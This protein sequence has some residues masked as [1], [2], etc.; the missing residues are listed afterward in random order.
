M[1]YCTCAWV[2]DALQDIGGYIHCMAALITPLILRQ[3]LNNGKLASG[4]KLYF[5]QSGTSTPKPVYS[6]LAGTVAITQPVILDASGWPEVNAIYGDGFY[7]MLV[8]DSTGAQIVPPVDG[9]CGVGGFGAGSVTGQAA[10]AICK[11]YAEVRLLPSTIDIAIVAGR[12][13][14]GD[15]GEGVFVRHPGSSLTDDDGIVLTNAGGSIV[16]MREDISTIDPRWYG[17]VYGG[18]T[19]QTNEINNALAASEYFHYPVQITGSFF[20]DSTMTVTEN[21]SIIFEEGAYISGGFNNYIMLDG[22]SVIKDAPFGN[23]IIPSFAY[24]KYEEI[25]ISWF[26]SNTDDD[27]LTKIYQ[28][29][30]SDK[31]VIVID[32]DLHIASNINIAYP[33]RM[34]TGIIYNTL[35]NAV[36]QLPSLIVPEQVRQIFSLAGASSIIINIPAYPE[37]FGATGDG[38]TNDSTA[39]GLAAKTGNIALKDGKTYKLSTQ[40]TYPT[41]LTIGGN[42]TINLVANVI[43][44]NTFT[45]YNTS[46][47]YTGSSNWL[48]ATNFF[49]FNGSFPSAFVASG[50]KIINGCAYSDDPLTRYPAFDGKPAIY[51]GYLPLITDAPALATDTNGKI[52]PSSF[53]KLVM[54]G[55]VWSAQNSPRSY[56]YGD[57]D[58]KY[59]YRAS[60]GIRFANGR[61]WFLGYNGYLFSS[62]DGIQSWSINVGLNAGGTQDNLPNYNNLVYANGWYLAST[63]RIDGTTQRGL[64]RST[65]GV[66]WTSANFYDPAYPPGGNSS[67]R[68]MY[69]DTTTSLW[70][71]GDYGGRIITSADNGLSWSAVQI[72][73]TSGA[74]QVPV[75]QSFADGFVGKIDGLYILTDAEGHIYTNTTWGTDNWVRTDVGD[76]QIYNVVKTDNG[77]YKLLGTTWASGTSVGSPFCLT[78]DSLSVGHILGGYIDQ[79]PGFADID[80]AYQMV[81]DTCHYNGISFIGTTTYNINLSNQGAIYACKDGSNT[82]ARVPNITNLKGSQTFGQFSYSY[83]SS[84]FLCGGNNKVFASTGSGMVLSTH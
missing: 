72:K 19:P 36:I 23:N 34:E 58:H 8:C 56:Y 80:T 70:L 59:P 16:W 6:D 55:M 25:R 26:G 15:G 40:L 44:C 9:V 18:V 51:N 46:I 17:L 11:T 20:I 74:S 65:N 29:A 54:D 71:A 43:N 57:S 62:V 22:S 1:L 49:A 53:G 7:R 64:M 75:S 30:S 47:T 81:T 32:K 24:P 45:L 69:Y 42:A 48:N 35:A 76:V 41:A 12:A 37:Y 13:V 2:L 38:S 73:Y 28:S 83:N 3:T 21:A 10:M 67:T 39:F 63:Y 61:L 33:V 4:G 79:M 31:Q 84:F 14:D 5:Y 50:T 78:C 52:I 66:S 77:K 27:K 60:S 82:W 68:S